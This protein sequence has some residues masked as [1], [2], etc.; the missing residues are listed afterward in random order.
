MD[1]QTAEEH[2]RAGRYVTYAELVSAFW[3]AVDQR[4]A[5]RS[6]RD[7]LAAALSVATPAEV[8]S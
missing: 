6:E 3:A 7:S 4:D 8:A 2:L 5:V 1:P